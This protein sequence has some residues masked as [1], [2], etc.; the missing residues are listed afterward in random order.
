MNYLQLQKYGIGD[1]KFHNT[2]ITMGGTYYIALYIT[3]S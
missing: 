2:V 1:F 3:I